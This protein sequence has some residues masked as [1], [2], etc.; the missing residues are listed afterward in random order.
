[1]QRLPIRFVI[2]AVILGISWISYQAADVT[3]CS[4]PRSDA[5]AD[6]TLARLEAA[7]EDYESWDE[8]TTLSEF[9]S[10]AQRAEQRYRAQVAEDTI[11]CID[12]LQDKTVEFFELEWKMYE[13][14]SAGNFDLAYEYD[15][16]SIAAYEAMM[17]EIDKIA[18][19]YDW[20]LE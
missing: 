4:G 2:A 19:K 5:W 7:T 3:D 12:K 14:G 1:M 8:Y 16:D 18:E 20:E 11:S 17:R 13:A 15:M 9:S 10:L 6:A